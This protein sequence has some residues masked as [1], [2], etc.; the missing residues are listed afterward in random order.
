VRSAAATLE[1]KLELFKVE[2]PSEF[3]GAFEAAATSKATGALLLSS[4][5]F[6]G[7]PEA[8]A[9]LALANRLPAISIFP[10]FAQKGGLMAYGPTC[11]SCIRRRGR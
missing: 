2:H 1:L 5:L 8:L 4:P 3:E 6:A 11:S 9:D 10:N 7:N